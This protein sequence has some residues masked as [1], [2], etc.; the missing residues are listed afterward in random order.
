MRMP[1]PPEKKVG[2]A[3]VLDGPAPARSK[4]DV[5]AEV[6]RKVEKKTTFPVAKGTLAERTQ[7][8][9]VQSPE[10]A[11]VEQPVAGKEPEPAPEP[12]PEKKATPFTVE[13]DIEGFGAASGKYDLVF[14]FDP[15][16]RDFQM[17]MVLLAYSNDR[18]RPF[19]PASNV[20]HAIA[21]GTDCSNTMQFPRVV[22]LPH[23]FRS[24][25]LGFTFLVFVTVEDAESEQEQQMQ[26]GIVGGYGFGGV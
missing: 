2:R 21:I 6:H 25:M 4:S 17:H 18:E 15:E 7:Q 11:P 23:S 12:D 24:D 13:F 16:R 14:P 5:R 20:E 3:E 1:E 26:S 22:R 9:R 8:V 10:D 19:V